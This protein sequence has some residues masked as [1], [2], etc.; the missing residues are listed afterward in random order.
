MH[1]FHGDRPI[2][3]PADDRFGLA[4]IAERIAGAKLSS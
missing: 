1:D 3:A 4:T 2:C